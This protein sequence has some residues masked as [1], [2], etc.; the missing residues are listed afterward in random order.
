MILAVGSLPVQLTIY[1]FFNK[2][3]PEKEEQVNLI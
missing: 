1:Q 2:S 3:Y